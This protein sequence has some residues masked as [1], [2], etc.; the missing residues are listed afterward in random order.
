[1]KLR[2]NKGIR[3]N[4]PER[5]TDSVRSSKLTE[6]L[7]KISR[8]IRR[9]EL[10][11]KPA[12]LKRTE[13]ISDGTPLP[14]TTI[15]LNLSAPRKV[16]QP[17]TTETEQ[18]KK[19]RAMR[20]IYNKQ[21]PVLECNGCAFQNVCPQFKAG[22]ECAYLPFLNSH[23]VEDESDLIG[24]MKELLGAG[25][26]RAHQ[27]LLMETLS[28]QAP[29][30]ENTEALSLL[31]NQFKDFLQL[32]T[33]KNELSIETEDTSIIGRL[34]GGLDVL[35]KQTLSAQEK[36][37]DVEPVRMVEDQK[38]FASDI[39]QGGN[40]VDNELIREHA[41]EEIEPVLTYLKK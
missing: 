6:A 29:S 38:V 31:F 20:R 24:Y 12:P 13:V 11:E 17:Q 40:A 10:E 35:V 16:G 34:F 18:T 39:D 21:M 41:R 8:Q 15:K 33:D 30:L 3:K 19:I 37:I 1:M 22:Y 36:S 7:N 27:A 23:K 2:I 25:M 5:T 9:K 14:K 26:R 32:M 4:P 28:G